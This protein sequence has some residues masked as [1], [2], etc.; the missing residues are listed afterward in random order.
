MAES[1]GYQEDEKE[2]GHMSLLEA[3]GS[4]ER[5]WNEFARFWKRK[6]DASRALLV[7]SGAKS[8]TMRR[9]TLGI[10]SAQ[11]DG[12]VHN[13]DFAQSLTA[14]L[15][16]SAVFFLNTLTE[17]ASIAPAPFDLWR[18]LNSKWCRMRQHLHSEDLHLVSNFHH[19]I[20]YALLICGNSW[21]Q[22]SFSIMISRWGSLQPMLVLLRRH[23]RIRPS[24]MGPYNLDVMTYLVCIAA[25]NCYEHYARASCGR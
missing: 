3:H 5:W 23:S 14:R 25:V 10:K 1:Q 4:Y 24:I 20:R 15:W 21:C 18:I 11:A 6:D 8:D 22:F 2:E 12:N 19:H 9:Q 7:Y 13:C 17:T 16:T